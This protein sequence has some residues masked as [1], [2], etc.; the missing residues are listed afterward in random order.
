MQSTHIHTKL[1]AGMERTAAHVDALGEGARHADEALGDKLQEGVVLQATPPQ[2][3]RRQLQQAYQRLEGGVPVL[4]P[5][6][7]RNA[8]K[9][10]ADR[11]VF[12]RTVSG[13][14]NSVIYLGIFS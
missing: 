13:L 10:C 4:G 6:I 9:D 12:S 1:R 3:R 7:L 14:N 5:T 2:L 11:N 8:L